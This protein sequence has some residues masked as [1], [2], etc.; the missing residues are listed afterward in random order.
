MHSPSAARVAS[1]HMEAG[2]PSE[3]LEWIVR[4]WKVLWD[5]RVDFVRGPV[6]DAMDDVIRKVA[7]EIV[8]ALGERE[9][10]DDVDEFAAGATRG[11]FDRLSNLYATSDTTW[12]EEFNEG[13]QWGYGNAMR[14]TTPGLPNDVRGMVVRE[15]LQEFRGMVTEHVVAEALR[16]A[17]HAV[18][19]RETFKSMIAAVKKHGW[20]IG[21]GLALFE[22]FEHAVLPT[23]L[24]AITGRPEMV[25]TGTMPLG[26]IILPIVLTAI[27][28][29]PEHA[30]RPDPDGHLD[31]YVNNYG[32]VK[33]GGR[34]NTNHIT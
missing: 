11:R 8:I 12:S 27:G 34:L 1:R 24:I 26:E 2:G 25:V 30:D 18:D 22:L 28:R 14:W 10:D 9:V 32:S 15:S 7:P 13:Y 19:P 6:D 21:V 33:I 31:W 29:V 16:K 23:A 3:W 5:H 4:P 17:W 20:K